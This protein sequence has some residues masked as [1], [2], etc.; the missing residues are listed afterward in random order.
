MP[1]NSAAIARPQPMQL[2]R[3]SKMEE[4]NKPCTPAATAAVIFQQTAARGFL[5]L[6]LLIK[7]LASSL[8]LEQS[9][10]RVVPVNHMVSLPKIAPFFLP[11]LPRTLYSSTVVAVWY[12]RE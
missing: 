10:P 8:A 1:R 5:C 4:Q 7:G 3:E 2:S 6:N 12:I 9:A 11:H